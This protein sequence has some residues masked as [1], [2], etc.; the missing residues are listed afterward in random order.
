MTQRGAK[1][2]AADVARA[3]GERA[4]QVLVTIAEDPEAAPTARIAAANA[5]LDRAY[6]K[7]AQPVDHGDDVAIRKSLADFYGEDPADA[8]PGFA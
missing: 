1:A 7:A 2:S 3:H 6:G 8:E 5:I 4:F